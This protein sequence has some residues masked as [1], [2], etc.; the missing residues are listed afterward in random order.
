MSDNNANNADQNQQ[1]SLLDAASNA[2]GILGGHAQLAQG[3][4]QEQIGNLLNSDEWKKS[5]ID[6]KGDAA[7]NI[8][9]AYDDFKAQG[10]SD[11]DLINK[12]SSAAD[13]GE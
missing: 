5:G 9:K 1:G 3:A 12:F 8:K 2:A 6:L 13:K 7:D 10:G 11:Q 4:T